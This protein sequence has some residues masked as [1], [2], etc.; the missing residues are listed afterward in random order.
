M[1]AKLLSQKHLS[2]QDN[3]DSADSAE[4]AA[5]AGND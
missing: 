5:S 1:F 2:T 3:A 4:I